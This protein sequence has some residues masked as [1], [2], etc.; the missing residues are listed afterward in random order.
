MT[1]KEVT[2]ITNIVGNLEF[3][4]TMKIAN[5]QRC[6]LIFQARILERVPFPPPGDLPSPG[7]EPLEFPALACGFLTTSATW[8]AL[9]LEQVPSYPG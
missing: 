3:A 9:M 6:F 4:D 2:S 7:A 8:E 1:K 5:I